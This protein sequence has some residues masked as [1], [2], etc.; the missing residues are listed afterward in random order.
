MK[1]TKIVYL[2]HCID[3]TIG[4]SH[5]CLLEI[6]RALDKQRYDATVIF[7]EENDLTDEF[8]N[9]GFTV[10][11][12]QPFKVSTSGKNLPPLLRRIVRLSQNYFNMLVTRVFIWR[13]ILKQENAD[14]LHL[15]NTFTINYD[16]ILAAKVCGIKV[17]SHVR[18]ID[19]HLRGFA[20]IMTRFI[21]RI[22]VI[23]NAVKD[24]LRNQGID[25]DR[26][27]LIYDGINERRIV[28]NLRSRYL[29]KAYSLDDQRVIFGL[30]GNI[31]PWKGQ[32]VLLE[33]EQLLKRKY[34]NFYCFFVGAVAD[35]QYEAEFEAF[36]ER[37]GLAEH[38]IFTGYQKNIPD[39]VNSFDIFVHAS[40]E[41]EPFGI[42]ILEAM[43]LRKPV[44][45]SDIGAPREI[46]V[47]KESGR[48]FDARNPQNLADCLFELIKNP[49]E[50][51]EMGEAGYQRFN[52][53][54]TIEKNV[55]NIARVY[56]EMLNN[57]N[58][59]KA[60]VAG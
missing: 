26:K 34:A 22:I 9:T 52:K 40:I 32:R 19:K 54:F 41:P 29:E 58:M 18:G 46:I 50:R 24:N 17:V 33:A 12:E 60:E 55:S 4:G 11:I 2:E 16:A 21:D 53:Y 23:S 47:D 51:N 8:R 7:Y 1:K 14:I 45:A 38:V 28:S 20:K 6:C 31:K 27:R 25:D 37:N 36:V 49:L 57:E 43:A 42:V 48:L 59:K 44:I 10:R 30:V 3:H 15:N 56:G 39:I 5:Y 35:Q 13:K